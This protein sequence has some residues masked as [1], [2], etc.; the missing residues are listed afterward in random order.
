MIAQTIKVA[1][2]NSLVLVSDSGGGSVPDPNRIAQDANV[3][4]TDTCV[5]VCCMPEIDG[6][7]EITLGW[8]NAIDPGAS[9][10]FDGSVATP[11]RTVAIFDV[12]WKPLL[13]T[14]V[15]T[16]ATRV[17]VWKN[18]PRFAD[19]IIIGLD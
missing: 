18:R 8:G 5:V 13:K 4:A 17:R 19:E 2:S 1:P 15:T 14:T 6:E 16:A 7:T 10:V 11:S 3:T 9:P 12:E